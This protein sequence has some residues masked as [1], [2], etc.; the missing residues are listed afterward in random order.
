[1]GGVSRLRPKICLASGGDGH[2]EARPWRREVRGWVELPSTPGGDIPAENHRG[3]RCGNWGFLP[4]G[5]EVPK[6][7]PWTSGQSP[8]ARP[9][10]PRGDF[11]RPC[12]PGFGEPEGGNPGHGEW[13]DGAEGGESSGLLGLKRGISEGT[14]RPS[15]G[16]WRTASL[17]S[18]GP[19]A[20]FHRQDRLSACGTHRQPVRPFD[21]S[22]VRLF[23]KNCRTADL[24][25]CR[26]PPMSLLP[27]ASCQLSRRPCRTNGVAVGTGGSSELVGSNILAH[28][29]IDCT[30]PLR[31]EP[32]G[33]PRPSSLY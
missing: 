21:G 10:P 1:M 25:C 26:T 8:L 31:G 15:V 4:A 27:A 12:S 9:S 24:P 20:P 23:L 14:V 13:R 30:P 16:G 6:K 28:F 5:S 17:P 22:P 11:S 18:S 2:T 29:G 7:D 32:A 19:F 33:L 3:V